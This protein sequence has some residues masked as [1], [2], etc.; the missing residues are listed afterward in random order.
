MSWEAITTLKQQA[1]LHQYLKSQRWKP[2]RRLAGGRLL[3]LCRLQRDRKPSFLIDPAK[4]LFYCYGC[5][6]GGDV[7]RFVEL[8]NGVSFSQAM[9]LVRASFPSGSLLKDVTSFYRTQLHRH[10]EAV[11]YLPQRGLHDP[12]RSEEREIG[13]AP[14][15][16][17]RHWLMTLGYSLSDLQRAGLVNANGHERG[18]FSNADALWLTP[19]EQMRC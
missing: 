17:L 19:S 1:P 18:P 8:Y 7:I 4:S 6:R 5:G 12:E 13:Y 3:G 2:V 15:F 14:G 11:H 10:P 9:A 16:C